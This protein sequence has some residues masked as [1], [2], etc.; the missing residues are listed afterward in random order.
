MNYKDLIKECKKR[1]LTLV[2]ENG[3]FSILDKKGKSQELNTRDMKKY[4][5]GKEKF[6]DCFIEFLDSM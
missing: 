2:E 6:P 3:K 5:S 4:K 1:S